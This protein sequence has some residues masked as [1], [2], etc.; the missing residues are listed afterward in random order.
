[1]Y[2]KCYFHSASK[3]I[4]CWDDEKGLVT[5]KYS[6]PLGRDMP[7]YQQYLI[8]K[9]GT[10]DTVSKG[11]KEFFFDIEIEMGDALT[12][13]YI[14]RAPKKVTSIAYWDKV[15]NEWGCYILDEN[16]RIKTHTDKSGRRIISCKD[17]PELLLRFIE[18]FKEINHDIIIVL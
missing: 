5:E 14:K 1:M 18:K 11:H 6:A 10:D 17:E 16:N 2:Q 9:Y 13:E 7:E 3:T 8:D 4:Y 15:G 12:E